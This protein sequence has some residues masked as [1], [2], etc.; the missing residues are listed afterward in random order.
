MRNLRFAVP[1]ALLAGALIF[2]GCSRPPGAA[3][4]PKPAAPTATAPVPEKAPAAKM[5]HV[6]VSMSEF[7]FTLDP[8]SV[9]AGDVMFM[10]TNNG[11]I[12]H[13]F[14]IE[15]LGKQTDTLSPGKMG[16]LTVNMKPGTYTIYCPVGSHRQL[17]MTATFTVTASAAKPAGAPG[18]TAMPG[19]PMNQGK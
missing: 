16:D 19:M 9:P 13:A 6:T 12:D 14:R 11:T 15:Q 10:V 8:A 7:K 4:T 3:E 2:A 1:L 17:G 18:K 5:S